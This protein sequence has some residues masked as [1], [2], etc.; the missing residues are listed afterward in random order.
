MYAGSDSATLYL[1]K[2][3]PTSELYAEC[4]RLG[5]THGHH[6]PAM[7]LALLEEAHMLLRPAVR[8]QFGRPPDQ[9]L[10]AEYAKSAADVGCFLLRCAEG[11]V[12]FY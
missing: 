4:G 12:G 9:Q 8:W 5:G 11:R 7:C 10:A 2:L 1:L 6:A 3:P